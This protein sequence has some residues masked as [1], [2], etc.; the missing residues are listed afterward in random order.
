MIFQ[1]AAYAIANNSY[2]DRPNENVTGHVTDTNLPSADI[3]RA[4]TGI[5]YLSGRHSMN[6]S[7]PQTC[8]SNLSGQW[9]LVS[10][11]CSTRYHSFGV[12]LVVAGTM[13]LITLWTILGNIMVLTALCRYGSLRTMS[14]CLIGNLAISDLLLALTVMP[15]STGHDLL[16]YWVHGERWCTVWLCIDVLYCTASIWGLCTVAFD[17][18]MATVYPV[19]YHDKR[20]ERKA[21][22][23]IVFV[24]IF[25]VIVSMAPFIGWQHMIPHFFT[26]NPDINKH[27][28]VLFTSSSYV[29]YSATS[30]FV[31]PACLMGFMYIRIFMVLHSQSKTMKKKVSTCDDDSPISARNGTL[32]GR[33][34]YKHVRDTV[35]RDFTTTTLLSVF[36]GERASF[37]GYEEVWEGGGRIGDEEEGSKKG[38]KSPDKGGYEKVCENRRRGEGGRGGAG[39]EI[40]LKSPE[41]AMLEDETE[42][43]LIPNN[44]VSYI[45]S[46][47]EPDCH[48]VTIVVPLLDRNGQPPSCLAVPSVPHTTTRRSNSLAGPGDGVSGRMINNSSSNFLSVEMDRRNSHHVTMQ[49]SASEM[50]MVS[51]GRM[52]LLLAPLA[53]RSKSAN[54]LSVP[55]RDRDIL[56]AGG[57]GGRGGVI[58]RR[59]LPCNISKLRRRKGM[60]TSMKRRFQLRE[61]RA[62]KRMLL[63]MACFCVCWM[64]FL[65]MYVT[66]SICVTCH[67]DQHLV[68]AIIWLGYV[69]SS[70]NPVLYTLFNDDFKGAFKDL[71][72]YGMTQPRRRTLR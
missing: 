31:L 46:A 33:G 41:Q 12:L 32:G 39:E 58:P 48:D 11:V 17:R 59:S 71:I 70:L 26:F 6:V 2:D 50:G 1:H 34:R 69:N 23:C 25:S 55:D 61:Q 18:Y 47:T 42:Q 22:A 38:E 65:V 3:F 49:R 52:D 30:S 7:T 5:G 72:G 56:G 44:D 27:D 43:R 35:R 8:G 57:V 29:I 40:G 15:I 24:W 20:S 64:P 54:V 37:G 63:I 16:G 36:S 68:A 67:L 66:R 13:S 51:P 53:N 60:T 21:I 4:D 28:C 62:T 45:D 10:P 9:S 14:N 19:W